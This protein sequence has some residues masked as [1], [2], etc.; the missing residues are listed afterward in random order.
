MGHLR[1]LRHCITT[2][3][4]LLMLLS[5]AHAQE[6]PALSLMVVPQFPATVIHATWGKL[7]SRFDNVQIN[8]VFA[9][10]IDEFEAKFLRGEAD[11]IYCNPY[12]MVMAKRAQGYTPLI[13]D[14]KPLTGILV[15]PAAGQAGHIKSL[16]ELQGKTLLF[17]SPNA[18]GASL[19]MRALLTEDQGLKFN[20]QY[21]KTHPNVIR[22]VVRGEGAAGGM[23]AATYLSEAEE[24]RNRVSILYETPP[25]APHPIAVHPR[26][27][28]DL[29]KQLVTQ[30]MSQLQADKSTAESLQMGD[31]MMADYKR[32]YQRLE[33]LG[34]DKYLTR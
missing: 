29:Q 26:V 28:A 14:T 27:S 7:V 31:P 6:K 21:V 23:V 18:F 3:L 5:T 34:L 13:R 2:G 1:M 19:Y 33:K 8:M 15:T 22:G 17:P 32:D 20:T 11:L 24:L 4:A 25:T 12:H 10:D 9:K 16:S 30:F